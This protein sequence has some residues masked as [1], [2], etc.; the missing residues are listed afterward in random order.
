MTELTKTERE[1]LDLLLIGK[2]TSDMEIIFDRSKATIDTHVKRI[3]KKLNY[4]SRLEMVTAIL[5]ARIQEF[6]TE[7]N[8]Q[9]YARGCN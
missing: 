6:E 9:R 8:R 4:N 1:V 3:L 2:S 7:L 5:N